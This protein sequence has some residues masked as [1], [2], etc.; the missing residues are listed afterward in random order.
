V[1]TG[2]PVYATGLQGEHFI[3]R[4]NGALFTGY[5]W[6][7]ESVFPDFCRTETRRWWG[8]LHA[9][10]L[11]VGVDGVWCDMNEPAIVDRPFEVPGA[12]ALAIPL[13]AVQGDEA[14]TSHAE[15]H[16]LYG[17]LM[18]RAT[19]EGLR[20]LRP[21]RRPWVLTRSAA[22]GAQRWA[23]SWMGDNASS[24]ADLRASLPQLASMGLSGSPHVGV[25]IGGFYGACDSELFA[26]WIEVGTFYPFMRAHAYYGS[27]PQEPWAFGENTEAVARTAIER[28]YRLLPYLYTLAHRAHRTGEPILRPLLYDFPDE[29]G[30]HAIDDQL[31][32]GPLLM[33]AP[34]CEPGVSERSVQLPPGIWYDFHSGRRLDPEVQTHADGHD[35]GAHATDRRCRL[36]APPG[37]MP[38]L[39]RGGS[40][41][42][43]GPA[44]QST[45]D[46]L[47]ELTLDVYPGDGAAGSWTLI[48]DA[49]DGWGYANGDLAETPFGV[50]GDSSGPLLRL[51]PRRGGWRPQPRQLLL[52]LHLTQC[53]KQLLLDG[54]T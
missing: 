39:V 41:L 44:R 52:R 11:D 29:H 7:G 25:D 45:R 16:N 18:A 15:A 1:W 9:G 19:H 26:R 28:R 33:I 6:P 8:D 48:E 23:V 38:I 53:P 43:L 5:V 20:R 4:P 40:C 42:T 30:L 17:L 34:V 10:L 32:V 22:I 47:T 14:E 37:R 12:A 2:Y 46:P 3:R 13:D 21:Q 24:W 51:G 36:P 35:A 27:P 49:G 31:M 50:A 54:V